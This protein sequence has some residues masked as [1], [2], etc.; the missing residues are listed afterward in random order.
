MRRGGAL[1]LSLTALAFAA[2]GA[3]AGSLIVRDGAGLWRVT[4]DPA[5]GEGDLLLKHLVD[6]TRPD[7]RFGQGG[8]TAFTQPG[9]G[10]APASVRVDASRRI[11]MVS[12]GVVGERPQPLVARFTADGVPDLRWGVRG[13]IKLAP[14]GFAIKPF[15][16][17][18]LSDGSVL[19]AGA[20]AGSATPRAIVFHLNANGSLD[21]RFGN[22]GVWQR[23]D[24]GAGAIATSL[25]ANDDGQAVVTVA[26]R[27][28]SPQAELWAMTLAAPALIQRAP[29][30][31]SGD[32]E[33]LH[34]D[35]VADHWAFS[36]LAG[37]TDIVPAA[38]LT[39]RAAAP[40]AQAEPGDTGSGGLNPFVPEA[41][42]APETAADNGG[43]PWTWI[44]VALV[45]VAA[46]AGVFAKRSRRPQTL[47]RKPPDR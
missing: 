33:E 20:T 36:G 24:D 15:D 11:W 31:A 17:L 23:P 22:G 5:G 9:A 12:N 32:G 10:Q 26:V 43:P 2:A 7:A 42:S 4:D 14:G 34:A 39:P 19:V 13:E 29:L 30:D 8:Q 3:H 41:A 16:L 35:W 40:I 45:L 6:G 1:A 38:S 28:A 18:P 21:G 47:L 37:P 46:I 25:A 44:V 27:G